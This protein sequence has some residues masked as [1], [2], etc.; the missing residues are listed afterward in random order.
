MPFQRVFLLYLSE[1][2]R[3]SVTGARTRNPIL[4]PLRYG[5]VSQ[6]CRKTG[7]NPRPNHTKDSKN[8]T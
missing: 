1:C 8:D 4:Y 2:E 6:W 5:D 7:F 3:N